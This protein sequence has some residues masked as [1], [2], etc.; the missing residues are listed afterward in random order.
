MSKIYNSL[1]RCLFLLLLLLNA[2]IAFGQNIS[3]D[4]AVCAN[5]TNLYT[6]P[7]TA[8]NGYDWSVTPSTGT[9]IFPF[10]NHNDSCNIIFTDTGAFTIRLIV[11]NNGH[12]DTFYYAVNAHADPKPSIVSLSS[13]GCNPERKLDA[14]ENPPTNSCFLVCDSTSFEYQTQPKP[15]SVFH[16]SSPLG[17]AIFIDST[18]FGADHHH[19]SVTWGAASADSYT[20]VVEEEDSTGCTGLDYI[21]IRIVQRPHA[22]ITLPNGTVENGDTVFVCLNSNVTFSADSSTYDISSPINY[23][24]WTFTNNAHTGNTS[25]A[26]NEFGTPG[27][28]TVTL[29]VRTVCGCSDTVTKIVVVDSLAG[30][31]CD[32]PST[33]CPLQTETYTTNDTCATGYMWDVFGENN[34]LYQSNDSITVQWGDGALGFGSLAFTSGCPGFCPYPTV[35]VIPIVPSVAQITGNNPVC[36]FSSHQYSVPNIPSTTYYWEVK[37]ISG[38]PTPYINIIDTLDHDNTLNIQFGNGIGLIEVTVNF[39]N[40]FLG[41]GGKATDTIRVRPNL[42]IS[43]P[44]VLCVGSTGNYTTNFSTLPMHW[45]LK[46]PNGSTQCNTGTSTSYSNTFTATGSYVLTAEDLTGN[47]CNTATMNIVVFDIPASPVVTGPSP[48]CPGTTNTYQATSPDGTYVTWQITGGTPATASGNQVS[49]TWN[50]TG[51]YII[52]ASSVMLTNPFCQSPSVVLN[53]A[54]KDIIT[55]TISGSDSICVDAQGIQFSATLGADQYH[56]DIDV[57]VGAIMTGFTDANPTAIT[58]KHDVATGLITVTA[59]T[60]GI[61]VQSSKT[62]TLIPAPPSTIAALDSPFCTGSPITFQASNGSSYTWNFGDGSP[63]TTTTSNT[64]DHIFY[65]DTSYTV[66]VVVQDPSGCL[67]ESTASLTLNVLPSPVAVLTFTGSNFLCLPDTLFDVNFYVTIQNGVL[68]NNQI[69]W[70]RNGSPIAGANSGSYHA[71]T[72]GVYQ[73]EVMDTTTGCSGLSTPISLVNDTCPPDTL[74][75]TLP[76]SIN[77]QRICNTVTVSPNLSS[78]L[79][80]YDWWFEEPFNGEFVYT[81]TASH[82]YNASGY[83]H[84]KLTAYYDY[85]GDTCFVTDDT[86][87]H[88]PVFVNFTVQLACTGNQLQVNLLDNS[89]TTNA[90]ISHFSWSV[91]GNIV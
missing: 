83:Y 32:C 87:I 15:G 48:I 54:P 11:Y 59:T 1:T 88:I 64:I 19:I 4:T 66:T 77:Y 24:Y 41:C 74:C 43:G 37:V 10:T 52:T 71:T 56:W 84:I 26:Q 75:P 65:N 68:A 50:N 79:T 51:P 86:I 31:V 38:N 27:N 17:G 57:N 12:S 60:C 35:V 55:P 13:V 23:W 7:H 22:K 73:V 67:G 47:M 5:T 78:G 8:G 58:T 20:L 29:I 18:T 33:V 2:T 76:L 72:D 62:I 61:T 40:E 70:Y 36:Q 49:I 16:W 53:I 34:V 44:V 45:C 63:D 46:F 89:N 81:S 85:Q 6:Y 80:F 14:S 25:I 21:C 3:G 82:T 69:I 39:I 90:T 9:H 28:F 42:T 91:D 30:P